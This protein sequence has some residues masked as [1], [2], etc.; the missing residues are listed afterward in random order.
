MKS[1]T[2]IV[3]TLVILNITFGM[4]SLITKADRLVTN[5]ETQQGV[6]K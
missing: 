1:L 2:A 5:I 3:I 6:Q 4:A